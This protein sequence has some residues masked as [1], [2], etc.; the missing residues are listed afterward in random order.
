MKRRSFSI[1]TTAPNRFM[2]GIHNRMPVI[3]DNASLDDWLSP[4]I[5]GQKELQQLMKP[6]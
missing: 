3:L 1:L 4:D 2:S 6:G 5:H